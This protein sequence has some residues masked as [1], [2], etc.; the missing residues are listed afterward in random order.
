MYTYMCFYVSSIALAC[1]CSCCM[2]M[3]NCT[4]CFHTFS[5]VSHM[6][7]CTNLK[8]LRSAL[9]YNLSFRIVVL[10]LFH[11]ND[12]QILHSNIFKRQHAHFTHLI[13]LWGKPVFP[14]FTLSIALSYFLKDLYWEMSQKTIKECRV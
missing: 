14:S 5:C 1:T 13:Y 4:V 2:H 12:S 8:C 6:L 3:L 7:P 10:C 9:R 11:F